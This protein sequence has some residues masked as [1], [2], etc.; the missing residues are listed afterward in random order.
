[1]SQ[2]GMFI[3]CTNSFPFLFTTTAKRS[4]ILTLIASI[5]MSLASLCL[6][7]PL[8]YNLS[9]SDF[10]PDTGWTRIIAIY[11][12]SYT[13]ADIFLGLIYYPKEITK[14][15]GYIHHLMYFTYLYYIISW[16]VSA[17]FVIVGF[18]ELPTIVL[19][20]GYL[21]KSQR[22][23]LLFGILFFTTRIFLHS[24]YIYFLYILYP[25][26]MYYLMAIGVFPLNLY[27]FYKWIR[28]QIRRYNKYLQEI[29]YHDLMND[30]ELG[31]DD[32]CQIKQE[33]YFLDQLSQNQGKGWLEI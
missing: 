3:L 1:M 5:I 15:T 11:F 30:V 9:L 32:D 14:V 28:Q 22:R 12:Q 26:N 19:G 10:G 20:F 25:S 13:F 27:W 23:D 16:N 24:I 18:Q 7:I 8:I 17:L 6:I 2:T 21:I 4:W 29:Q 33:L 31:L